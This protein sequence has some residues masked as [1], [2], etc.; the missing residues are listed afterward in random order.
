MM[1]LVGFVGQAGMGVQKRMQEQKQCEANVLGVFL[2]GKSDAKANEIFAFS[3]SLLLSPFHC[4]LVSR[5]DFFFQF[6]RWS[7]TLK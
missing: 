4:F 2:G 3:L 6:A 5:A 1:H 7:L